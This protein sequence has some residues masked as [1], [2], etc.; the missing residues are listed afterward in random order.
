MGY[1]GYS[2][3]SKIADALSDLERLLRKLPL[4]DYAFHLDILE[5][6]TRN[7]V[8]HP[9]EPKYRQ[10]STTNAK[11]GALVQCSEAVHILQEMG[12]ELQNQSMVLPST[13]RLEFVKHVRPL[14]EVRDY[15]KKEVEKAK[16]LE[17]M[18]QD[19]S[20]AELLQA[21]A[22]DRRERGGM[23]EAPVAP[24]PPV[25]ITSL[26]SAQLAKRTAAAPATHVSRDGEAANTTAEVLVS[27]T[28][29]ASGS[30]SSSKGIVPSAVAS[31]ATVSALLQVDEQLTEKLRS[32]D[33]LAAKALSHLTK[34]AS[35]DLCKEILML[36]LSQPEGRMRD[37]ALAATSAVSTENS[38]SSSVPSAP[39]EVESFL[40]AKI[41]FVEPLELGTTALEHAEGWGDVTDDFADVVSQDGFRQTYCLGR[42]LVQADS[43]AQLTA[44]VHVANNGSQT[45]S[46]STVLVS[47]FGDHY[48][49]QHLAVGSAP[50]GDVKRIS[51]QLTISKKS[52]VQAERSAWALVDGNTGAPL[53]PLVLLDVHRGHAIS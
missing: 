18:S 27:S 53:G 30:S 26:A 47:A 16:K 42:V 39:T 5:K 49:L 48:G 40:S 20:K 41:D 24:Q 23:A 25:R 9:S 45:W 43:D 15:Y 37:A 7:V 19:P 10:V 3:G 36:L 4:H 22:C 38:S 13:I 51:L 52:G 31:E 6:I 35:P 17:R 50:P 44:H 34:Q 21:L 33:T 2:P 28:C 11:I 12:W 1:H 29:D 46:P 14:I 32:S 8:S